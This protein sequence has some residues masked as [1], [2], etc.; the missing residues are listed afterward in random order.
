VK[1]LAHAG[2]LR[3]P[4]RLDPWLYRVATRTALRDVQRAGVRRR[5]EVALHERDRDG[6]FE[7]PAPDSL[8]I[9]AHLDGLP[10]G[11]RAA[12]TLRY[13]FDLDDR[14]IARAMGCRTA[15]VRSH[16]FHGRA[17]LRMRLQQEG[18]RLP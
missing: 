11:Q 18:E 12:L 10:P 17:A 14:A 4:E 3:R 15:T 2:R 9:T 1:A 13:V 7:D 5:A 16:L 6:P 8:G